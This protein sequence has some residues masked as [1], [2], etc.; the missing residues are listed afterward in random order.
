MK[1][2]PNLR[3]DMVWEIIV[4]LRSD[5]NSVKELNKKELN[6]ASE[7]VNDIEDGQKFIEKELEDQKEKSDY[8]K[9]DLLTVRTTKN[10]PNKSSFMLELSHIPRQDDENAINLVNKTAMVSGIYILYIYIYIYIYITNTYT[11]IYIE[12][13]KLTLLTEHQIK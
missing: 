3:Y 2:L 8:R 10:H 4:N 1:S 11:Y 12:Y 5:L 13:I 9:R 7:S 6:K